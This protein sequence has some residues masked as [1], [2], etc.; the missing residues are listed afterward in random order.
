MWCINSTI[1]E[2]IVVCKENELW[3]I[4]EWMEALKELR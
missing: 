1:D 4:A 2:A 3:Q